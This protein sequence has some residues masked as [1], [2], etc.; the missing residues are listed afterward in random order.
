M[1]LTFFS[2]SFL[3]WSLAC[4]HYL[5]LLAYKSCGPPGAWGDEK[6]QLQRTGLYCSFA[7]WHLCNYN[8]FLYIGSLTIDHAGHQKRQGEETPTAT[9]NIH[10]HARYWSS[11]YRPLAALEA[12]RL[13]VTELL[14][15]IWF[16]LSG[17]CRHRLSS[18]AALD[19]LLA[20]SSAF[21]MEIYGSLSPLSAGH[22]FSWWLSRRPKEN[23]IDRFFLPVPL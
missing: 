1:E 19:T 7:G 14:A 2:I 11:D 23:V 18:L 22:L 12:K 13:R 4:S 20:T 15:Y 3:R 8:L 5:N 21:T 6:M 16:L 17:C 10:I 9:V